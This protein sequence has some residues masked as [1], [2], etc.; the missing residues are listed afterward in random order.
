MHSHSVCKL[1]ALDPTRIAPVW[2]IT[3]SDHIEGGPV[4]EG[5]RVF[6]PAGND[7]LYA[8]DS[9]SGTIVWNFRA[10]LHIDST[11][12]LANRKLYIGSGPSRKF[13]TQEVICLESE[14]GKV[15]WRSPV[16]L[17]A[18]STPV[19]AGDSVFVGLGNGRL[20]ESA[21]QP[22]IPAGAMVC[23]DASDGKE[24][25]NFPVSDAIFS[26][27]VVTE[28]RVIFGSR[29]GNLY[30]LSLDGKEMFRVPF[31]SPVMAPPELDDGKVIAVSVGGSVMVI[32][33]EDGR[34]LWRYDMKRVGC[35]PHV[36]A[37]PRVVRGRLYLASE[38]RTPG[39]GSGI[40]T[41]QCFKMPRK[42]LSEE[43]NR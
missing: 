40:V 36:Y 2:A 20:T 42:Q 11:P 39:A 35:E 7:G 19:V 25:W 37:G 12:F 10:D 15:V 30:G 41:L 8:L 13:R 14:N 28:N 9:K 29:D 31:G 17:P 4:V 23:L 5:D 3:V 18:W 24:R 27:P 32:N 16:S 34:E 26:R 43:N 21:T 1:Y 6:F 33:A 22:D 38:M